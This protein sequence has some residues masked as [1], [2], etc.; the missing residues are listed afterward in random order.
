VETLAAVES[1][2]ARDSRRTSGLDRLRS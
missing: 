1:R 2:N